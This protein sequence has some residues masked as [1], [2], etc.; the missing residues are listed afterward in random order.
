MPHTTHTPCGARRPEL[1]AP[2]PGTDVVRYRGVVVR[3]LKTKAICSTCGGA[4]AWTEEPRG[5]PVLP[6]PVLYL[7]EAGAVVGSIL[8]CV[9]VVAFEVGATACW[10]AE[11]WAVNRRL[12]VERGPRGGT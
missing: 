9:G 8:F 4:R 6:R 5:I 12:A 3:V 1:L 2:C 11:Q 10:L 7:L